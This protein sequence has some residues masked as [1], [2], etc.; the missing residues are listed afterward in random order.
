MAERDFVAEKVQAYA[1]GLGRPEDV[2][3]QDATVMRL[4]RQDAVAEARIA[5]GAKTCGN[6]GNL[7]V[8]ESVTQGPL[9]EACSR[10][11]NPMDPYGMRATQVRVADFTLRQDWVE[12]TIEAGVTMGYRIV[13]AG[14]A[15]DREEG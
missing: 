14:V 1:R 5:A 6:C 3:R 2:I 12:A 11:V 7:A 10:G 15:L 13:A 9:C 8:G 4:V